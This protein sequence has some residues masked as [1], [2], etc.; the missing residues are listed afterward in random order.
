MNASDT[1][2]YSDN[3]VFYDNIGLKLTDSINADMLD[4]ALSK[5]K[6]QKIMGIGIKSR[7]S[8]YGVVN[9]NFRMYNP[10]YGDSNAKTL[11][12][13]FPVPIIVEH[14]NDNNANAVIGRMVMSEFKPRGKSMGSV[15][16]V[17]YAT[18]YD[19]IS[20]FR[21]R[22]YL[23]VSP[24]FVANHKC[25]VC[26]NDRFTYCEH[27]PG[28][29]YDGQ[30]AYRSYD[31]M[32]Y[33]HLA[34]VAEP[35]D[36]NAQIEEVV[37]ITEGDSQSGYSGFTMYVGMS[38]MMHSEYDNLHVNGVNHFVLDDN[39]QIY[40]PMEYYAE[41][42]SNDNKSVV[43]SGDNLDNNDIEE[44]N[45]TTKTQ[46]DPKKNI[47]NCP[48]CQEE[49]SW[50]AEDLVIIGKL[51][52]EID[53]LL[54]TQGDKR[55]TAKERKNLPDSAFC[56]PGRSFPVPDC[57][58]ARAALSLLGR[59]DYAESTKKKIRACVNRK[60]ESM[61]CFKNDKGDSIIREEIM[62]DS[63]NS[64]SDLSSQIVA[65]SKNL[66]E[67]DSVI[68]ELNEKLEALTKENEKLKSEHDSLTA[69]KETYVDAIGKSYIVLSLLNGDN[70]V[71]RRINEGGGEVGKY[72][73]SLK[74][75]GPEVLVSYFEDSYSIAEAD[76]LFDRYVQG[77]SST[78][79]EKEE[80][81]GEKPADGEKPEAEGDS[82]AKDGS[83]VNGIE[84]DG[85]SVGGGNVK[86]KSTK[87]NDNG[88]VKKLWKNK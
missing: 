60:A 64:N 63:V 83:D 72:L 20:R 36:P 18:D 68:S 59:S 35:A 65:L 10:K 26:G 13:P 52:A 45:M 56:G 48:D 55:L 66:I 73:D 30:L 58:H 46:Q 53:T 22:R 6:K 85:A 12:K 14:Y 37:D 24:G 67:K 16:G 43:I 31:K 77:D 9:G 17:F 23:T 49:D 27:Q 54:E 82:T 57:K 32:K 81:D 76:G 62:P 75:K 42:H 61:K 47:E 33:V 80:S 8:T 1:Q 44:D 29:K 38:D 84:T 15:D 3:E 69:Q 21:D 2:S 88:P 4:S 11:V 86:Q 70:I 5:L 74:K 39:S 19:S 34:V 41:K 40:V 79:A 71:K 87:S 25:S 50:S 78:K 28:H 51:E 7:I